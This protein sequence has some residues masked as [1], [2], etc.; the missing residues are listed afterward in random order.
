MN[1]DCITIL[2]IQYCTNQHCT[3][4]LINH[5]AVQC[6]LIWHCTTNSFKG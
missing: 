2:A 1:T 4:N 3:T 5:I 6:T